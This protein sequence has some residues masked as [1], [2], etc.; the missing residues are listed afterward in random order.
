M[1][2][3]SALEVVLYTGSCLCGGVQYCV[4]GELGPIELCYCQQYRKASGT[5]FAANTAVESSAFHITNG[6]ELIKAFESSPGE[7]RLFCNRCGSPIISRNETNPDVVR[8]RAGTLNEPL[9]IRPVAHF[10]TASKCNWWE[11]MDELP[12]FAEE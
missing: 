9:N 2:C 8:I 1:L 10:F 11:I 12:Q 5:S 6:A 7:Q 4:E 3:L